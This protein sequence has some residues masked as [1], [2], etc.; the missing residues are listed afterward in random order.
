MEHVVLPAHGDDPSK[1][2]TINNYV[3]NQRRENTSDNDIYSG[4]SEMFPLFGNPHDWFTEVYLKESDVGKLAFKK[5]QQ[6][7][8]KAAKQMKE[9]I[10]EFSNKRRCI[11]KE[12]ESREHHVNISDL[13]TPTAK[14]AGS[15]STRRQFGTI[16]VGVA[17]EVTQDLSPGKCSHGGQGHVMKVDGSGYSA[18][19]TVQY[20]EP[21]GG[22]TER[23]IGYD[24]LTALPYFYSATNVSRPKRAVTV[25]TEKSTSDK[26]TNNKNNQDDTIVELLQRSKSSGR[27]KGWRAKDLNVFT[28]KKKGV[29]RSTIVCS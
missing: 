23:G 14:G 22:T 2:S 28:E 21:S 5:S 7:I 16:G 6:E 4:L 3:N 15:L 9:A 11:V 19:F 17:V 12:R 18:S 20:T 26:N 8:Q 10:K 13:T 29:P 24:R 27:A 25:Q 1:K